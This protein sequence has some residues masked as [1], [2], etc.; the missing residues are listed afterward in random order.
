MSLPYKDVPIGDKTFRVTTWDA[1]RAEW[2]ALRAFQAV[3]NVDAS[4]FTGS[5][6]PD[7]PP[8]AM[9]ELAKRG[10][11]ALSRI[12]PAQ[13]K[14]LLEEMLDGL[15]VVLPDGK[16]RQF[17]KQDVGSVMQLFELRRAIIEQNMDFFATDGQ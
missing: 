3:A 16:T 15:L 13:A 9:A 2:W 1:F 7:S 5:G 6:D 12:D 14:P 10:I 17:M 4:M 8:L 11:T